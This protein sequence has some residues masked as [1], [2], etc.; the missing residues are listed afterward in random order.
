MPEREDA[1]YEPMATSKSIMGVA[2][3][4]RLEQLL[5]RTLEAAAA[6]IMLLGFA[7]ILP[8]T[9]VAIKLDSGGPVLV[10]ETRSDCTN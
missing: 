9:S 4:R 7:P 2:L 3:A 10:R 5:R 8:I 6:T 1:L